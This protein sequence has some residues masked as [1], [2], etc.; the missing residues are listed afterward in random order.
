MHRISVLDGVERIADSVESR[1]QDIRVKR[2]RRF[3]S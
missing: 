3:D 2:P 1:L